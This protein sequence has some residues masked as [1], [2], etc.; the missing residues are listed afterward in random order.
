MT[1]SKI[2]EP[3]LIN[4]LEIKNRVAR[5]AHGEHLGQHYVSDEMIAYHLERAKNDVGLSI[6]GIAEVHPSS[7]GVGNVWSPDVIPRFQK[8]TRAIEPYGMRVFQQLWHGGHH[9]P[10]LD[11]G[12]PLAVSTVPSPFV[13]ALNPMVGIPMSRE[14]IAE[15]VAAYAQAAANCREGG[16]HGVEIHAAHSYLPFQF[17]NPVTNTREDDYG[18]NLENRMRFLIE[19]FQA[20]RAAV[21]ADYPVGVRLSVTWQKVGLKPDEV[22]QVAHRLQALGVD[23][24]AAGIGDYWQMETTIGGMQHPTGYNLED[25]RAF[26][27]GI[28]VPRIVSGRFRT[29]EE[30]DQVLRDGDADLVG[31]VRALIADPQLVTKTLRGEAERVRPCIACNQGCIG[32]IMRG[33]G[34]SCTVNPA[35]GF[36][37]SLSE[38]LIEPTPTPRK[39]VIVGGGPA[40][41]EA[42]RIC[43]LKGH[44]VILFEAAPRLGGAAIAAARPARQTA[45]A[46]MTAWQEAELFRLGV[47]VRLNSYAE[48]DDIL[49]EAPDR[50][51]VA[52]GSRP[53]M[54]GYQLM[55]PSDPIRGV[56]QPHVLSSID[57]LMGP[58]RDLG[59]SAL[60]LDNVGHFEAP[61][62]AAHLAQQGLAVTYATHQ[63]A[64]APYVQTTMRDD[65]ILA[66]ANEGEFDLLIDQLLIEIRPGECVL[67]SKSGQRTRTVPADTVILVTPNEPNRALA[68]DLKGRCDR[69]LLIGDARSPRDMLTA[70]AEGHRVARSI[71]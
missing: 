14:D 55:S 11:W 42:A 40:G 10:A 62:C 16:V 18:G 50:V 43:T 29:L 68:D 41:M 24:I 31:M 58:P 33:G 3:I 13:R 56:D 71:D 8:L 35:A 66:M 44:K 51:L 38:D 67:R 17:L 48:A 47:D 7:A 21:G 57:L 39:V 19:V 12:P 53:R 28:T 23:Y 32:N 9:Y 1:L 4:R 45:I 70:I 6:F 34:L 30:A 27:S 52:T 25:A 61:V 49:A 59:R 5:T 60:V 54:D 2:L 63:R 64:F 69:V 26:L 36:E 65:S 46:D 22:N 20:I 15:I 37:T